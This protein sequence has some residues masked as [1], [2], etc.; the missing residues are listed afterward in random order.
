VF[1]IALSSSALLTG[2][3]ALAEEFASH[4]ELAQLA[5]SLEQLPREVVVIV[6]QGSPLVDY[7]A[8]AERPGPRQTIG[9]GWGWPG[10]RLAGVIDE[11]L[12]AG[13]RLLL[14]PAPALWIGERMQADLDDLLVILRQYRISQYS[15]GWLEIGPRT[16]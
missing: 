10:P 7:L 2:R 15:K 8:A 13:R 4:R 3:Y 16:P 6:G 11:H 14:A 12:A 9:P 1:I 5:Q